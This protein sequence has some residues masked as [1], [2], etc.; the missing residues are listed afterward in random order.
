MFDAVIFDFGGVITESP[1]EAFNR[2]EAESGIPKDTIRRIN[3]ANP[4]ENAWA[5]FERAEMGLD[6]FDTAF[7]EEARALGYAIGGRDVLACLYGAVRP[8][9][10][11]ALKRISARHKTGCS[12]DRR[13]LAG[14]VRTRRGC[15]AQPPSRRGHGPVRPCGRVIESRHPQARPAHLRDDARCAASRSEARDLSRRSRHQSETGPRDR[16][17]DDDLHR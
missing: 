13:S 6:A 15:V 1:F 17:D 4:H 9:M 5:K 12:A 3:A 8:S 14:Q 2:L 16:H 7:A 10:L 11:E